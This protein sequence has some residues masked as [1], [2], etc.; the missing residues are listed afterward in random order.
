MS[1]ASGSQASM[2][3]RRFECGPSIQRE[4]ELRLRTA[5]P[6]TAAATF[7]KPP[8]VSS[9]RSRSS[10][11]ITSG[12]RRRREMRLDEVGEVMDVDDRRPDP[13]LLDPVEGVVEE[14]AAADVDQRLRQSSP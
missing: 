1:I 10:E 2:S 14:R 4:S 13:G 12:R 7:F 11:T 8:P 9:S 3:R 5:S 6:A